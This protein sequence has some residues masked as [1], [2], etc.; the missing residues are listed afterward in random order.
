MHDRFSLDHVLP[1]MAGGPNVI[2]NIVLSCPDCNS[3]KQHKEVTGW[4]RA[5][6]YEPSKLLEEKLRWLKT[7]SP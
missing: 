4:L 6:G 3:S 7:R 5:K 2:Q 1:V